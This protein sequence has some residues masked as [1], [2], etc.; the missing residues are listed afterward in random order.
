ME[1]QIRNWLIFRWAS[2]DCYVEQHVHILDGL[3]WVMCKDPKEVYGV[4]GRRFDLQYPDLGD[5]F[6]HFAVD[7]DFGDGVHC[8]SYSRR[9]PKSKDYVLERGV[10]TKGIMETHLDGGIQRIIG[11]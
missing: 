3:S 7:F 11:S 5:R 10:G 1:Y 4:G 2:G 9:E 8:A 6:S